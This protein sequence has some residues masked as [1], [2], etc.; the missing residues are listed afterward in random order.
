MKTGTTTITIKCKDGIIMAADKRATAGHFIANKKVEK[1]YPISDHIAITIAGLV[2]DAQLL[3]KYIKA[4]IKLREIKTGRQI[5]VSEVANLL[6][7]M[8]YANIRN[9]SAVQGIVGFL[10]GG[11]DVTGFAAYEIGI[12][13]S[14]TEIDEYASDGSGSLFAYAVLEDKYRKDMTTK[15][16]TELAINGLEIAQK[17]DSA[18][19]NGYDVVRI[20]GNGVE[21]IASYQY[22]AKLVR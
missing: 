19:G 16:A 17:R 21:K 7:G 13:G 2:S 18:S 4:E 22:D 15:D 8:S 1:V 5:T 10:V 20:A 14:L 3:T 9:Y 11:E 12:D 6:A